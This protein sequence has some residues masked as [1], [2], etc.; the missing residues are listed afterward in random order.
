MGTT[1]S[2][3]PIFGD[4]GGQDATGLVLGTYLHGLFHND[5]FRSALLEHLHSKHMEKPHDPRRA[6]PQRSTALKGQL[7]SDQGVDPFDE[8][9]CVVLDHV[10]MEALYSIIG[11]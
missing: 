5:N 1:T 4:D 7:P 9:A 2:A 8:L 6:A 3:L 11:L 10:D